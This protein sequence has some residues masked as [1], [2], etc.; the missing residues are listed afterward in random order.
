MRRNI[1][2]RLSQASNSL[3]YTRELEDRIDK[4]RTRLWEAFGVSLPDHV[5][6]GWSLGGVRAEGAFAAG[7]RLVPWKHLAEGGRE[8]RKDTVVAEDSAGEIRA[9]VRT[10]GGTIEQA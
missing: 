8:A 6:A 1:E 4:A 9:Y 3:V 5:L 7:V 2:N 10:L